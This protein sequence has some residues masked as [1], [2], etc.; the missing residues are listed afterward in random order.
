MSTIFSK[1]LSALLF[2][3]PFPHKILNKFCPEKLLIVPDWKEQV[4]ETFIRPCRYTNVSVCEA[5]SDS[6]V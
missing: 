6:A 4:P 3:I 2:S 5:E 1:H